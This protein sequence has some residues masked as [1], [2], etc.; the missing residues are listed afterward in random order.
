MIEQREK[1]ANATEKAT[2][3]LLPYHNR[4]I[5]I[6][7]AAQNSEAACKRKQTKRFANREEQSLRPQHAKTFEIKMSIS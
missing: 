7:Q 2:K 3:S 6:K 4:K 1:N 5:V